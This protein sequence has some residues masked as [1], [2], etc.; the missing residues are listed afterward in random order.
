MLWEVL[1]DLIDNKFGDMFYDDELCVATVV[2]P[3]FKLAIFDDDDG[4]QRAFEAT[5]KVV[6]DAAEAAAAAQASSPL[7]STSISSLVRVPSTSSSTTMQPTPIPS[8]FAKLYA[9]STATPQPATLS[10]KVQN[11]LNLYVAAKPIS[12]T[13]CATTWWAAN[14]STYPNIAAVARQLLA[15]P[16]TSVASERLFSKAGGVI[17]KKRNRLESSKAD[18]II[19]LME[20]L[21]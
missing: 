9:P 5:K 7:P 13:A 6:V 12:H 20:N 19:F 2:G 21:L 15:V 16:G 18:T 10:D 3:R 8:I 1:V 14:S 11:E 4:H 17:T